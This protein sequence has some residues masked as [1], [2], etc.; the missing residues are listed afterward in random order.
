M[1]EDDILAKIG[2][3]VRD[4][5]KDDAAFEEIARGGAVPADLAARAKADPEIARRLSASRPLG[6]RAEAR[7]AERHAKAKVM[8]LFRR[9]SVYLAPLALAAGVFL[10]FTVRGADHGNLPDYE[11]SASGEKE[12]RGETTGR[13]LVVGKSPDSRFEIVARP[14][15]AVP[16]KVVAYAFLFDG[17]KPSALDAKVEVSEAGSVRIVGTAR[18]LEGGPQPVPEIRIVIGPPEAIGKHDDALER[19]NRGESDATVRVLV[20]PVFRR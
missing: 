3:H 6:E 12:M 18:A 14:A 9:A 8:P 10:F 1:T 7:I 4:D 15:A 20:L 16:T 17:N 11:I 13:S 19:A 2:R 5:Q